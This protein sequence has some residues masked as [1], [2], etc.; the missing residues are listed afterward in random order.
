MRIIA[1]QFKGTRLFSPKSLLIRPT[2][3]RVREF[4]F[5]WIGPDILGK[6]VLDLFAGTGAFGLEAISRGAV[7]PVFVDLSSTSIDLVKRNSDKIGVVA[8]VFRMRADKYLKLA[9]EQQQK[10]DII[11]CDPPYNIK[12]AEIH[13]KL[14]HSLELLEKKNGLL[15]FE[16]TSRKS[17]LVIEGLKVVKEKILGDTKITIYKN[18][19]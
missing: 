4:V 10:F 7:G 5:S 16:S 15:I 6:T 2:S 11:F 14:I 13:L 12:D 9:F 1:G 8:N 19:E 17:T 18:Y 3:D